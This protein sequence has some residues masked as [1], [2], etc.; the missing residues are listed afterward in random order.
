MKKKKQK[1]FPFT[2]CATNATKF[3]IWLP[4]LYALNVY[5][6]DTLRHFE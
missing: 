4:Y 5:A 3:E 6:H 1:T 2:Q